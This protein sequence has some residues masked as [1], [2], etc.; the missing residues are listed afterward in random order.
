M[1]AGLAVYSAAAMLARLWLAMP[2]TCPAVSRI[3]VQCWK[4]KKVPFSIN[5]RADDVFGRDVWAAAAGS[6]GRR[7]IRRHRPGSLWQDGEIP[8]VDIR[9]DL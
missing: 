8:V 6:A 9:E 1:L 5:F 3:Y 2:D 7:A 4:S